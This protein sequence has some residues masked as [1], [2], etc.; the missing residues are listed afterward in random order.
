MR[1]TVAS[2][3]KNY[4]V[5]SG[6]KHHL[7]NSKPYYVLQHLQ[8]DLEAGDKVYIISGSLGLGSFITMT[9]GSIFSV[10]EIV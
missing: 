5:F 10:K 1:R 6:Y 3:V 2:V 7:D 9:R 8:L 4:Q